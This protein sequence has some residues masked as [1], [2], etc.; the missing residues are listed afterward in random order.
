MHGNHDPRSCKPRF[1]SSH[2]NPLRP[3]HKG[4]PVTGETTAPSYV[5]LDDSHWMLLLLMLL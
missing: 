3:P 2:I 5:V 1:L 4:A